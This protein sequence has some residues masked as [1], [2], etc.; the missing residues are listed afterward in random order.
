MQGKEHSVEAGAGSV[1]CVTLGP[2]VFRFTSHQEWVNKAQSWFRNRMPIEAQR[3]RRYLAVDAVG[4]VCMI[5]RDFMRARDEGTFPVM[6]CLIDGPDK[7]SGS[8][9]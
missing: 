1:P 7:Q 9:T 8:P 4:R 5:G 3:S 2:E 6:V